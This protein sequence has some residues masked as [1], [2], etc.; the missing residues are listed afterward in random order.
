MIETSDTIKNIA[1]ALAKAQ[2]TMHGATKDRTN[3][4]YKSTYATMA[5]VLEAARGPLTENGISFMQ[6]PGV[7]TQEG[8]LPIETRFWHGAS[9]EW[10]KASFAVPIQ[11]RDPQGFG[12]AT[13]YGCRYAM[14]AALGLPPVDDDG[15]A[16]KGNS[17]PPPRSERLTGPP[18]DNP[19]NGN[20]S[21][22]VD[23]ERLNADFG[24]PGGDD[25]EARRKYIAQCQERILQAAATE[26]EIRNWWQGEAQT[27]RDFGLTQLEVNL[28]K[29]IIGERFKKEKAR[30]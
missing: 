23:D 13:T 9:G 3:P 22:P 15:E 17:R 19:L 5:S 14:M 24:P 26:A 21:P 18:A 12:S 2:A 4:A 1:A 6:S 30:A 16:A 27:R 11:K 8:L 7:V 25:S 29:S 20:G 10:I 28:L